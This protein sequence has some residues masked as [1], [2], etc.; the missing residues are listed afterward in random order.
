MRASLSP[1]CHLTL[2]FFELKEEEEQGNRVK[3]WQT[4][5]TSDNRCDHD[6]P[7]N[8]RAHAHM[9]RL[10]ALLSLHHKVTSVSIRIRAA[11]RQMGLGMFNQ[12]RCQILPLLS[13]V[14]P[15]QSATGAATLSYMLAR[16]LLN[17]P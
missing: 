3:G 16:P 9:R 6:E 5:P 13:I 4:D 17:V 14:E 10:A 7:Q 15:Y 12:R 2:S 8:S 1:S 11:L